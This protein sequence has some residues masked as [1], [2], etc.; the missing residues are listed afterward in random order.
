MV[1]LIIKYQQLY[2]L[3]ARDMV[4]KCPNLP[5]QGGK[6]RVFPALPLYKD[7]GAMYP[8]TGAMRQRPVPYRA[9]LLFRGYS[10]HNSNC[11]SVVGPQRKITCRIIGDKSK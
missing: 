6:V 2:S 5:Y 10:H 9:I 1:G 8:Y 4:G 11:Y 3:I 7:T